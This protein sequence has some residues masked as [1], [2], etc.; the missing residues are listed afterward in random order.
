[1]T[2]YPAPNK[3]KSIN[4][5]AI[6]SGWTDGSE[7]HLSNYVKIYHV[8]GIDV[9]TM[10]GQSKDFINTTRMTN[11]FKEH[12]NAITD[13]FKSTNALT[14][15]NDSTLK[16]SGNSNKTKELIV[17]CFSNG[18]LL[19][20]YY[21]SISFPRFNELKI[22]HLVLD[23]CPGGHLLSPMS[24]VRALTTKISNP[25]LKL[26]ASAIVYTF[27]C[28][29]IL[30]MKIAKDSY[31][32][33]VVKIRDLLLD[34]PSLI[35]ANALFLY[36]DSDNIVLPRDIEIFAEIR[37][38]YTFKATEKNNNS[39]DDDGVG[40]KG[41]VQLMHNFGDS[42]H[43]LHYKKYPEKYTSLIHDFIYT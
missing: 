42:Q 38:K 37:K 40:A 1:M 25:V 14:D 26:A 28:L 35:A 27:A 19:S 39:N 9:Y 15:N 29:D 4:K 16:S 17:H 2:Y 18:G 41:R 12:S 24:Y 36:S 34:T 10:T 8:L 20:L 6:L 13:H 30:A 5:I 43:V 11:S 31:K 23:S 7:R 3:T 21:M 32:S 33:F 22:S